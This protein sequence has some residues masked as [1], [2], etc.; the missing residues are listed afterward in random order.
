MSSRQVTVLLLT[1]IFMVCSSYWFLGWVYT[2]S[3]NLSLPRRGESAIKTNINLN[4]P[5]IYFIGQFHVSKIVDGDTIHVTDSDGKETIVRFIAVNTPETHKDTKRNE[6]L[7][8]L[9]KEFT[10]TS[11]MNKDVLL[12]GDS[13]QPKLD[14]YNR[15]LAYVSTDTLATVTPTFFF[16]DILVKTGNAK[17]YRATPP[18]F[19]FNRYQDEQAQA[20]INK[21]VMWNNT[22]CN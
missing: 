2:S 14:K 9:A 4:D 13:T 5:G 11:L 22:L 12:F 7:G 10:N 18:A 1:L 17:V 20:Q 19:Y 15:L 21:L 6:C 16:N 8:N 3:P